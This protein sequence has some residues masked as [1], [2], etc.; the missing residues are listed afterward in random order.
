[1]S[2]VAK[3]AD[4]N[5][6]EHHEDWYGFKKI[7]LKGV[8]LETITGIIP[9]S[10]NQTIT[11]N[12]FNYRGL[13][14][15]TIVGDNNL[16]ASNIRKGVNIFGVT[17]T[18]ELSGIRREYIHATDPPI[19][20]NGTY[21]FNVGS[22]YDCIRTVSVRVEVPSDLNNYP[23]GLEINVSHIGGLYTE[24]LI[25]DVGHG[26]YT[27]WPSVHVTAPS[28]LE[29]NIKKG[30]IIGNTVG[31]YEVQEEERTI[32]PN[33]K[34]SHGY[35]N[36]NYVSPSSDIG[37]I[38]KLTVLRDP[39]LIP[40]NIISGVTIYGIRGEMTTQNILQ[41]KEYHPYFASGYN[42][43]NP[44]DE[45]LEI[46]PDTGFGGMS[47]VHIMRD[48]NLQSDNIAY[49]INMFGIT[50]TYTGYRVSMTLNPP[51]PATNI[52]VA[53]HPTDPEW[54]LESVTVTNIVALHFIWVGSQEEFDNLSALEP[55][56]LYCIIG[57]YIE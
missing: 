56:K 47:S 30:I 9:S 55:H 6:A 19:T 57:Q 25:S 15:V 22:G 46:T 8:N 3:P 11:Y 28:I 40:E 34:T 14:S 4:F 7:T 41:S 32:T 38:T 51:E 36:A 39:N 27:G 43:E 17:G 24:Y 18:Y 29:K 23:S 26:Q 54:L 2:F 10:S 52:P 42:V 49:G 37:L 13:K 16:L 50:G 33:F 21:T 1:M 12:S 48:S 53:Y 44:E 45:L 20:N 35:S 31:K 5:D